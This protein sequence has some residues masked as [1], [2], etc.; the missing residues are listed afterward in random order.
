M[1]RLSIILTVV[2]CFAFSGGAYAQRCLPGM[3]GIQVM[4]GMVD[5]F[6]SSDKQNELGYYFG[7]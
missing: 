5:G 4:G 6:H 3:Q 2:L 7:L 1:K